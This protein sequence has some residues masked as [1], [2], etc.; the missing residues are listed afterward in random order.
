M[1][2]LSVLLETAA[3][4][5]NATCADHDCWAHLPDRR[6]M[7]VIGLSSATPGG[8]YG[9]HAA[10]DLLG[11]TAVRVL[12]RDDKLVWKGMRPS[13][14]EASFHSRAAESACGPGD[15]REQYAANAKASGRLRAHP[16]LSES[17][18]IRL[19]RSRVTVA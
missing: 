6:A 4:S 14:P 9:A 2:G 15:V 5:V 19:S 10:F 8:R 13:E 16:E 12:V 3:G 7:R 18:S 1:T 11:A 17:G